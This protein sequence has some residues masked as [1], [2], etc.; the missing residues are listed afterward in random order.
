MATRRQF[1]AQMAVAGIATASAPVLRA[2]NAVTST[3]PGGPPRKSD[4]VQT[5]LGPISGDRMGF[6]APHEHILASSTDFMRLWP[7]Y[8]GG[9]S[10]FTSGVVERMKVAKAGGL[11]TIVDCTTADLGRD[12][13][14]LQEVSRRSGVQ[15]IA[16]TGHWLTPTPSFEART[17]DEL[18]DFFSLEIER[19]IEDTGVKPGVIKA[20]SEGDGMTP[21][22]EKVFKAAARASKRTAVPVTTHS[23]ARHRGGEQQAAIFEQEGLDP[24]MVCIGHSD[25]TADFDYL[26]GLARRGY[27]LGFD[28][29]FYGLPSMGGGTKGIPTWQDRGAMVKRLIDAGFNE[30]I[31]LASDWMFALT[32]AAT[33][34]FDVL[35]QRNPFGNLFNIRNTIP[36]LRQLGV[37]DEQIRTITILNPKAFFART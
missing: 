19:G 24:G 28:H 29:P 11:D 25:E 36:Y 16:T 27:T 12:V 9:R 6:T 17:A 2:A 5:V 20:A 37:T 4:V 35:N 26:A 7:E 31:F 3:Q 10:R 34:S 14:L 22:Q 30:R 13:R 21:F 1:L 23:L 15:I 32:I 33:G 8:L 18:A